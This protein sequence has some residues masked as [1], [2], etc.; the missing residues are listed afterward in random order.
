[1]QKNGFSLIELLVVLVILGILAAIAI[2]SYSDYLV[3]ANRGVA[4]AFLLDVASREEV[5]LGQRGVYAPD[6]ATLGIAVPSDVSSAGYTVSIAAV[7][8]VS[9]NFAMPGFTVTATPAAGSRQAADGAL[10]INQFGLKTPV[11]KW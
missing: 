5:Y 6:I 1:M 10:S 9:A 2:P 11:E 8:S 7:S 3:F 4:K